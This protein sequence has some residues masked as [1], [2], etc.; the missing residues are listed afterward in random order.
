MNEKDANLKFIKDFF[1][2]NITDIC[3]DLKV[4]KGNLYVGKVSNEKVALVKD[5][6]IKRLNNVI[7]DFKKN[8]GKF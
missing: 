5:E 4:G 8:G 2:I 7:D 3:N 6:L 1:K